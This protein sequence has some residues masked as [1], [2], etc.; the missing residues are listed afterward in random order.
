MELST[1]R[2][3]GDCGSAVVAGEWSVVVTTFSGSGEVLTVGWATGM[4]SHSGGEVSSLSCDST[5]TC[6]IYAS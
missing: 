6:S 1:T 4:M 3:W 2:S 5:Q